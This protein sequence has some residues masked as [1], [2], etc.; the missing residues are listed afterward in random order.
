MNSAMTASVVMTAS[1]ISGILSNV[2]GVLVG[3][4]AASQIRQTRTVE[5]FGR[6]L[7]GSPG[8][9][10]VFGSWRGSMADLRFE[11]PGFRLAATIF[12]GVPP[13]EA[14]CKARWNL[15]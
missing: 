15:T 10:P 4:I 12:Q 1:S 9:S 3:K 13:S 5:V 7:R 14:A 6:R 2:L 11:V 8:R